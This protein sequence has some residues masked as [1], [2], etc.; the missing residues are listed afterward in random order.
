VFAAN[1]VAGL[2]A[3]AVAVRVVPRSRSAVVRR[4]GAPLPAERAARPRL[5]EAE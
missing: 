1:A 5:E 2:A 3:L 4:L